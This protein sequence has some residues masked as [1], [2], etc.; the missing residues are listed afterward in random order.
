MKRNPHP[1][2]PASGRGDT[3]TNALPQLVGLAAA[4]VT[5]LGGVRAALPRTVPGDTTPQEVS[6][7]AVPERGDNP[8]PV[9]GALLFVPRLAVSAVG[10][11]LY[12]GLVVYEREHVKERVLDIFFDDERRFGIYPMVKLETGLSPGFGVRVVHRDLFRTGTGVRLSADYGGELRRRVDAGITS[13]ELGGTGLR[14]SLRGGWQRQP[15]ASFY[16]IGEGDEASSGAPP[17]AE[18]VPAR[19]DTSYHTTFEQEITRAELG[20]HLDP[21]GP[22]LL[23]WAG[24]YVARSFADDVNATRRAAGTYD[25]ATL[26]AWDRGVELLYNELQLVVDTLRA[27]SPYTPVGVPSTGTKVAVFAG[28]AQGIDGDPTRYLRYG[29]DVI[30]YFDLYLGDRVLVLKAHLEAVAG[31]DDRIPFTDL[32]RLGG[33]A[34]LRGYSHGRFSDRVAVAGTAEYHWPI[35]HNLG[36]FL[37]FDA[38]RVLEEVSDLAPGPLTRHRPMMGGG[39]G[40]ELLDGQRFRLRGQAAASSE[41]LFFQLAFE[42]AYRVLNPGYRI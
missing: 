25:P 27:T 8:L 5:L 39:G 3:T 31:D 41:G 13:P 10:T 14:L 38:G 42:P 24:S 34:V 1:P 16:G 22:L 6:G 21:A 37:F 32:P 40:L 12:H 7:V 11:G 4:A 36:G 28:W 19:S 2:S 26:V 35:W 18:P 17:P 9:A 23:Q 29:A 30:R 33:T 15:N 20:A